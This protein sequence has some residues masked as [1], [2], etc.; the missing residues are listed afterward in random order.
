MKVGSI[1]ASAEE[2]EA[3]LGYD[4]WDADLHVIAEQS[5]CT[6]M[7][8][9]RMID[10][11]VVEQLRF[12]DDKAP[13]PLRMHRD[14]SIDASVLRGLHM[15]DASSSALLD[16]VLEQPWYELPHPPDID[17]DESGHEEP[18]ISDE[19][20][21]EIRQRLSN[22]EAVSA[23]D[24]AAR[25][26]AVQH[27][28]SMGF[29]HECDADPDV[30]GCSLVMRKGREQ[31]KLGVK[32]VPGPEL[33]FAVSDLELKTAFGNDPYELV[34]VT[35]PLSREPG[36]HRFSGVDLDELFDYRAQSYI[37]RLREDDMREDAF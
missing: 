17:G 9:F 2:A 36:V 19:D 7:F 33:A 1:L 22:T 21:D 4:P 8:F 14:G 20:F 29:E 15:L 13:A 10:R 23:L 31:W 16:T 11:A 28:Q 27:Y 26:I 32:G 34:V 30:D 25:I 3:A 35:Q 12:T 6:P 5:E 24:A 37:V 18:E